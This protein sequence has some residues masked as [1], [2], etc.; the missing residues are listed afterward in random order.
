MI[1]NKENLDFKYWCKQLPVDFEIT[2]W[3]RK[4]LTNFFIIELKMIH[5]H[6]LDF[7]SNELK[8]DNDPTPAEPTK[9]KSHNSVGF[10]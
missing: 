2:P 9:F 8:F 1:V 7:Q 5:D 6:E 10:S 3:E 4:Q